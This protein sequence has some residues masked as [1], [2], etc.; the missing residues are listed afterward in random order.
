MR[1]GE[2]AELSCDTSRELAEVWLMPENATAFL[3]QMLESAGV[4]K[5]ELVALWKDIRVT[6]WVDLEAFTSV[7]VLIRGS[8][9]GQQAESTPEDGG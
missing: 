3:P 9:G 4:S 8:G 2:V 1:T 6:P 5:E 7:L